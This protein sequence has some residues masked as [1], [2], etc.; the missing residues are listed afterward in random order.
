MPDD[1]Q[2]PFKLIDSIFGPWTTYD[3]SQYGL[4]EAETSVKS[5][6]PSSFF[7]NGYFSNFFDQ[8]LERKVE[9]HK[10]RPLPLSEWLMRKVLGL[11]GHEGDDDDDDIGGSSDDD[12]THEDDESEDENCSKLVYVILMIISCCVSRGYSKMPNYNQAYPRSQV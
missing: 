7:D 2:F 6:H 8:T 10:F 12:G 11:N 1:S 9:S 4:L 3:S 5:K